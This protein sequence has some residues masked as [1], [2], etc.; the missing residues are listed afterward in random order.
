MLVG[1]AALLLSR[2]GRRALRGLLASAATGFAAL[3][4]VN[5]SAALTGVA[6]PFNLFTALCCT[7]LGAPGVISLMIMKLFW[8]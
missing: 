4:I 8:V 5:L 6:L 7:V 1:A 3:G 2:A